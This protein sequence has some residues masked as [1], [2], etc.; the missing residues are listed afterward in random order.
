[1]ITSILETNLASGTKSMRFP[2]EVVNW[3][4][5]FAVAEI[6]AV[7]L[8]TKWMAV[9][10]AVVTV[11]TLTSARQSLLTRRSHYSRPTEHKRTMKDLSIDL[12]L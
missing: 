2:F 5:E 11:G 9:V 10:A 3:T 12:H 8:T 4:V 1:M 7:Q 6:V